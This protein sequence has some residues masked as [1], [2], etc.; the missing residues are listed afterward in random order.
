MFSISL[1]I[2]SSVGERTSSFRSFFDYISTISNVT[3]YVFTSRSCLQKM[4]SD[5]NRLP[6]QIDDFHE[7]FILFNNNRL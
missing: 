3:F 7:P 1:Y 5:G 2:Y 6:F 4:S